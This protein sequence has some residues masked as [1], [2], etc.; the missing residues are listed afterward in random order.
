MRLE[1]NELNLECLV[2]RADWDDRAK[3]LENVVRQLQ[4][5]RRQTELQIKAVEQEC[6]QKTYAAESRHNDQF[7]R[8]IDKIQVWF[9]NFLNTFPDVLVISIQ[10]EKELEKK[11]TEQAEHNHQQM[12][13]LRL[14]GD[15]ERRRLEETH[16]SKLAAEYRHH[17]SLE[18][19]IE[20]LKIEHVRWF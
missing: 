16:H 9:Y 5:V 4:E 8:A 6:I 2:L 15:N 19:Q 11:L 17:Q 14:D 10:F 1:E 18:S 3:K 12:M 13:Q 7:D 20:Q